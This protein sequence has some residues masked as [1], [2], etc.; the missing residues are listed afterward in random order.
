M[1]DGIWISLV[2]FIQWKL[3]GVCILIT[4]Q[5]ALGMVEPG[6]K[7]S[8]LL[9]NGFSQAWNARIFN[10]KNLLETADFGPRSDVVRRIFE[11]FKT[12]DFE[13]IMKKLIATETILR[14]YGADQNVIEMVVS[15]QETV[16]SALI[17]AISQTHPSLPSEV[18]DQQYVAVRTFLQQFSQIFTLNY[19]LLFYWARNKMALDPPGYETDD[20]FRAYRTWVGPTSQNVHFLH[21]GLHI[22]D[23]QAGIKKHACTDEGES[24]IEQ[25]RVN[26]ENKRFPTFVSEPTHERKRVRIQHNPYL[27]F[28][29]Q[30]L[31][32]L[33]GAMFVFGH[34][35]DENDK[36][37][38]DEIN[39]SRVGSVFVSIYGDP[40]SGEN[41]LAQARA[42]AYLSA[43]DVVF[44]TAESAP[45]WSS[46]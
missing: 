5:Q 7:K 42:N 12:Y 44:F 26:M 14:L 22:Y 24:I 40:R 28:C 15:D 43:K 45:V 33:D 46:R 34:S 16:K 41:L 25:V 4:Y 8:I 6:A 10:Y 35:I 36:H 37:I 21:G 23:T 39:N 38:F 3:Q 9:A 11:S 30:K 13:K 19:D 29:F 2:V 18:T 31:A 17:T 20:G 1:Y 27:N 32:K